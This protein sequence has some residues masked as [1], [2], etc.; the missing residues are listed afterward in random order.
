MNDVKAAQLPVVAVLTALPGKAGALRD[1][2]AAS[3]PAFRAEDGCRS[4]EMY[5]DRADPSRVV[6]IELWDSAD[7]LDAHFATN[8]FRATEAQLSGIL[9]GPPEVTMLEHIF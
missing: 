9:A 3:I 6:I 4:Y 8:A 5:I 2:V 7:A 1:I